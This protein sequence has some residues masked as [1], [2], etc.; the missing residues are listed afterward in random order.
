MLIAAP[1]KPKGERSLKRRTLPLLTVLIA[2]AVL[3]PHPVPAYAY[4]P[5]GETRRIF[6][7]KDTGGAEV[8][9]GFV[10]LSGD[11]RVAAMMTFSP[12]LPGDTN[13]AVDVYVLD[14]DSGQVERASV[15][16]DGSEPN[17]H[18]LFVRVSRDGRYVAFHS[19]ATNLVPND[20][21]GTTPDVYVRDMETS[22]T[23]LVSVSDAGV[24]NNG[25]A[26]YPD[27]SADGRFVVFHSTATNLVPND[28]NGSSDIFVRDLVQGTT[29]RASVLADGSQISRGVDS[30]PAISGD[31]RYVAFAAG[32]PMTSSDTNVVSRDIYVHDRVTGSNERVSVS[33]DGGEGPTAAFYPA[34]NYDGRYVS[35][36]SFNANYVPNDMNGFSESFVH[37][38]L[39]GRT[40]RIS[41]T[42][43]G[44][45]ANGVAGPTSLSDDGRYVLYGTLATNMGWSDGNGDSDVYRYDRLT[46]DV[47]LVSVSSSDAAGNQ[48]S[49][50]QSISGDGRLVAFYSEATDLG[51]GPGGPG[52]YLRDLGPDLGIGAMS[53]ST[54]GGERDVAGWARFSGG[55]LVSVDDPVGDA[56][57]VASS[58][59]ADLS[60]AQ[61]IYRP[62]GEDLLVRLDLAPWRH[63]WPPLVG[64]EARKP[65]ALTYAVEV[66]VD[67]VR[68]EIRAESGPQGDSFGVYRCQ[69]QCTRVGDASGGVGTE[70]DRVLISA[71]FDAL[72]LDEG[73]LLGGGRAY[74]SA[75]GGTTGAG[76]T[77][78]DLVLPDVVIPI[79]TVMLGTAPPGTL[80]EHV[81]FDT[82]AKLT[83]GRFWGALSVSEEEDVWARACLGSECGVAKQS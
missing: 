55:P 68:H 48:W 47:D 71:S 65:G 3:L 36:S 83:T 18:S 1:Q 77:L 72:G 30:D 9:P 79:S 61:L 34:I 26:S 54:A 13:G 20:T 58:G 63:F 51:A 38:R 49:Y 56:G 69:P 6:P 42:A 12:I 29:E 53:V 31:G 50:Q 19:E 52:A 27:I 73:D 28:T 81:H 64:A 74:V 40:E 59:G 44:G 43:T 25:A 8:Q 80:S 4:E 17:G 75:Q 46:N 14:M 70:S 78:D 76:T 62:E 45:E 57:P 22:T 41:V 35:F 60:Q 5:P 21:N 37:D 7:V 15:A 66:S 16:S 39:T 24:Q 82:P 2:A 11:G 33:S 23:T 32:D 10:E 67:G